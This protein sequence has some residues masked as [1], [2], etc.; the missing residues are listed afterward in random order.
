MGFDEFIGF[1]ITLLAVSGFFSLRRPS[2]HTKSTPLPFEGP[3]LI[4][5]RHKKE[6]IDN[7][8]RALIN[9]SLFNDEE[10]EELLL[11]TEKAKRQIQE[12]ISQLKSHSLPS[13]PKEKPLTA[14]LF[15][16]DHSRDPY[17]LRKK[18]GE[19]KQRR[20]LAQWVALTN[21]F[22]RGGR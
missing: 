19:S 18:R 8:Q 12:P 4:A 10:A 1:L 13:T 11:S 22:H 6:K 16:D 17:A 3:F 5:D 15:H 9:L 21:L 2:S 14:H 7:Q 20:Q